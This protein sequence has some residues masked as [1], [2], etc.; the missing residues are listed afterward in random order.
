MAEPIIIGSSDLNKPMKLKIGE[1]LWFYDPVSRSLLYY[2]GYYTIYFFQ[3]I[4]TNYQIFSWF[5]FFRKFS[6]FIFGWN[7][8][9]NNV[10]IPTDN[11]QKYIK[12][13]PEKILN[14]TNDSTI[15]IKKCVKYCV[16][17]IK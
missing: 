2:I 15:Y 12:G 14:F 13:K 3:K 4:K 1:S 17:I 7:N 6:I 10:Y 8:Y 16:N 11:K 9:D 5:Y